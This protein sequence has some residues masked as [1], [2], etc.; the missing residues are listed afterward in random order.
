LAPSGS[1]PRPG[2]PANGRQPP[3]L[4]LAARRQFPFGHRWGLSAGHLHRLGGS[5]G[6]S[7]G[8]RC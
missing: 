7:L 8:L 1:A 2:S 3:E 4:I 5:S 6:S